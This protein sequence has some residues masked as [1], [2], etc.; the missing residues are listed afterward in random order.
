[1]KLSKVGQPKN[2]MNHGNIMYFSLVLVCGKGHII[3]F[4]LSTI[5]D[6]RMFDFTLHLQRLYHISFIII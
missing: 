3:I 6:V 2:Q 4:F 1:M 5:Y